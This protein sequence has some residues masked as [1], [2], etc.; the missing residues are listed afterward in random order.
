MECALLGAAPDEVAV[1]FT[2]A[3]VPGPAAMVIER[4]PIGGPE[5]EVPFDADP[6]Q[7]V[8]HELA[9]GGR[10]DDLQVAGEA[11]ADRALGLMDLGGSSRPGEHDRGRQ[12]G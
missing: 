5:V 7:E 10:L 2:A 11:R 12:S 4:G 8:G 1:G 9:L 3:D 6:M